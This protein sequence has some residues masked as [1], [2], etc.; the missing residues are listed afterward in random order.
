MSTSQM[1]GPG[2]LVLAG[3]AVSSEDLT[4]A[5]GFTST[6]AHSHSQGAG[7]GCWLGP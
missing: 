1:G 6:V 3:A 5:G 7:D 4:G 2:F